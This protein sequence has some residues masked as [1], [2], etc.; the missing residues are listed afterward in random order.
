LPDSRNAQLD[1]RRIRPK[2]FTGYSP[3][4]HKN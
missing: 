3:A 4:E 1:I 2:T